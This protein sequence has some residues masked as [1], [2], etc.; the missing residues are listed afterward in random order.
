MKV[1]IITYYWPPAGGSGVQRW[2]KFVKYLRDFDIEPVVFTVDNPSYAIQ[3]VALKN[4]I[5]KGVEVLKQPIWEPNDLFSFFGSKNKG[6][7]AGF[8][9][10]NPSVIGKI[11]HYI[12]A[13]YFIPDARM[14]WIKPSV[15]RLENYLRLNPVDLIISTGPPHSVHLIAKAL[16]ANCKIPWIADFRDPWTDI[17]YFHQLPLTTKA[18]KRHFQLEK[19][20]VQTADA[21]LVVGKTMCETYRKLNKNT[22]VI[23]NG[24]DTKEEQVAELP[25]DAA[26]SLTHIGLMNNDRNHRVLWQAISELCQENK[27]FKDDFKLQ[28][29]GK[30]APEVLLSVQSFGLEEQ[31]TITNYVPHDKVLDFQKKSQVLLLSVNNVPSAKGI[32]TGKIF[33]YLH[34]NRPIIAI[35]PS[36]GDLAAILK[37]C[38][39]GVCIDFTDKKK[40]KETLLSYYKDYKEGCLVSNAQDID[41]F[42]RKSLTKT[43]SGI[44]C[45]LVQPTNN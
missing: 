4:E 36:Q 43:L 39:A 30:T 7:S 5:P 18:K 26:F 27:G 9:N 19:E 8:L 40:L 20:V 11:L 25:L 12:R 10:P 23:Y 44:I 33:E 38:N 41:Q 32:L 34:A 15:K 35:A 16:K 21:V 22:H 2:L 31:V 14:F 13:N 24:F 6:V 17:D 42:H 37:Q 29:I 28:L 45:T 1:L 3:D